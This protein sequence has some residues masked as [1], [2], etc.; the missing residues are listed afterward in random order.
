MWRCTRLRCTRLHSTRLRCT[1]LLHCSCRPAAPPTALV[2]CPPS[3]PAHPAPPPLPGWQVMRPQ[4]EIE[5]EVRQA[6]AALPEVWG[7]S[8]IHLLWD[9]TRGGALV[10]VCHAV[11]PVTSVTSLVQGGATPARCE[12]TLPSRVRRWLA[13]A[14]L[15]VRRHL[16]ASNWGGAQAG[17]EHTG[18]DGGTPFTGRWAHASLLPP[19]D[20][21]TPKNGRWTSSWTPT[22]ACCKRCGSAARRSG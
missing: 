14:P 6:L 4:V 7:C 13:C 15:L 11:T 21:S 19:K 22:C 3:A 2:T 18:A 10:Q 17:V 1:A 16:R 20:T 5:R 12:H 9:S 8:H